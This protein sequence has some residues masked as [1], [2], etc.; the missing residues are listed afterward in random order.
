MPRVYFSKYDDFTVGEPVVRRAKHP[1]YE[2]KQ[3]VDILC[4][5]CHN[6]F[7]LA[8]DALSSKA[9]AC[10]D[11]IRVCNKYDGDIAPMPDKKRKSTR[12]IVQDEQ[13][14]TIYKIV[15]IPENRAVYTGRT[16]NTTRRMKQHASPSSGCRL[17]RNAIRRHGRS[18]FAIVPLVRC[19]PKDADAN[20]SYYIIANK[21]MHPDGYNLRHG[22]MAGM[23]HDEE[24]TLTSTNTIVFQGVADEMRAEA[25]AIADLANICEDLDDCSAADDLCRE[26]LREVH[27]DRAGERSYS[28]A[29]V[30]AMLNEIRENI[31]SDV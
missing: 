16:K 1:P 17:L 19:M 6:I 30:A 27:P 9:K 18:K 14:V 20:E 8:A 28:A 29:E 11:H 7:E 24:T 10:L 3:Y 23:E 5:H 22:S 13:L 26:L 31:R 2:Q 15:Y 25:D 21:T 12:E 4:P